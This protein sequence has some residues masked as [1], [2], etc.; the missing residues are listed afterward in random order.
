MGLTSLSREAGEYY[1]EAREVSGEARDVGDVERT[2]TELT[3]WVCWGSTT[4]MSLSPSADEDWVF[5]YSPCV[6]NVR[7]SCCQ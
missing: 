5:S 4:T 3:V 6:E 7:G 1:L 2:D